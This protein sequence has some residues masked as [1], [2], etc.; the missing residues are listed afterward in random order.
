MRNPS[1]LLS[2]DTAETDCVDYYREDQV[3]RR[4]LS[5]RIMHLLVKKRG[6]GR[7]ADDGREIRLVSSPTLLLPSV[8]SNPA[9]P[10]LFPCH[11]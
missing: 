5:P 10:F 11:I 8:I 2:G 9:I 6:G 7:D 1:N 3:I 4:A